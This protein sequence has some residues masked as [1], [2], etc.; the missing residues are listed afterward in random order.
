MHA[1]IAEVERVRSH[2]P[3]VAKSIT[4]CRVADQFY[5]QKRPLVAARGIITAT[6]M[7]APF[8]ALFALAQYLLI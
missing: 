2:A 4:G 6:L 8:W 5:Y 1:Q 3:E 7:V